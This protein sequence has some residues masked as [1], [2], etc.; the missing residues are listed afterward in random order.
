MKNWFYLIDKPLKIT[1]FDILRDLKKKLNI[2]KMWHTWTLD[3]LA[4]GLVLVAVWNYTK[5]INYLEK[6]KK[7]YE[8]KLNLDWVT[9]SFDLQTEINFLSEEKQKKAKKEITK[10]KI[11]EI[12]QKKFSWK[13][14]QIPP[15]YSALKI[16]WKRAYNLAREWKNFELKSREVEIFNIKILDFSY[17]E[18]FL[19]AEVSAWT[20]IRSIAFD[21]WKILWIW[22]YITYLRRTKIWNLSLKDSQKL[23]EFSEEKNLSLKKIFPNKKI[24][25]L[26]EKIIQRMNNWLE[27]F[28]KFENNLIENNEEF[29]VWDENKITNIVKYENWILKAKRKI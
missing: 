17:P 10:E 22:A 8:F 26:P 6:D 28:Y 1:S 2:K 24:I 9:D 3:P 21:L 20:Y 15:K 12:L 18:L 29:F 23:E 14:N 27:T 19:K 25:S 16:N 11:K 13:I 4:S 5:L 7:T